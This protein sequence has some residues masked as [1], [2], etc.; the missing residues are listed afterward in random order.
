MKVSQLVGVLIAILAEHG[1]LEVVAWNG[2]AEDYMAIDTPEVLNVTYW[3]DEK[4]VRIS[5]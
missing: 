1:D 3:S 4:Q 5:S 2:F